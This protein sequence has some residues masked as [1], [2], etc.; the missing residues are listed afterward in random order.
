MAWRLRLMT[1]LLAMALCALSTS[2]TQADQMLLSD[3]PSYYWHFGCSPTSAMM[4]LGYW[5]TWGYDDLIPGSADWDDN[6]T[7]IREAIAS[8]G[9]GN[10]TTSNPGTPG[11]GHVADYAYYGGVSDASWDDPNPDMSELDP[12]NAHADDCLADF[13]GTS[14]SVG[15]L[16]YGATWTNDIGTGMENYATWRSEAFESELS[17]GGLLTWETF[18]NE[19]RL[20]R[21]VHFSVDSSGSGTVD[22]SI[23]AI[24]FRDINGYQEYACWDTWST[25]TV[26][27]QRFRAADDAYTWGV[28]GMDTLRPEGT[29]DCIWRG[30]SGSWHTWMKWNG[31]TP[32]SNDFVSIG[33]DGDVSMTSSG[34]A[35]W[36]TNCGQLDLSASLDVLVVRNELGAVLTLSDTG[37]SLNVAQTLR[38]AAAVELVAGALNVGE[39]LQVVAGDDQSGEV[40][41]G[42]GSAAIGRAL[43]LEGSDDGQWGG[44]YEIS[45]GQLVVGEEIEVAYGARLDWLGGTIE[46]A[47]VVVD[48]TL[49]IGFSA[50]LADVESGAVLQGGGAITPY[51]GSTP[52]TIAVV[53]GA[54]ITH[55]AGEVTLPRVQVGDENSA[56]TLVVSGTANLVYFG[57]YGLELEVAQGQVTQTGGDVGTV[58][59]TIAIRAAGGSALYDLQAGEVSTQTLEVDG[60]GSTFRQS[61]GEVAAEALQ[62]LGGTYD[63][64]DGLLDVDTAV[65]WPGAAGG[66]A[67]VQTGGTF[68]V[69]DW[70]Y[71]LGEFDLQGGDLL[72]RGTGD[73]KLY[74]GPAS[75]GSLR[76]SGGL[77]SAGEIRVRITD[78]LATGEGSLYD[79]S[80]GQLLAD[81]VVVGDHLG[82]SVVQSGGSAD[83]ALVEIGQ[84]SGSVGSWTISDGTLAA[85]ELHIGGAGQGSLEIAGA[86]A[87]VEVRGLLRLGAGG[88]LS[89]VQGATIRMTGAA[90]DNQLTDGTTAS[91]WGDLEM[92]FEGGEVLFDPFEI[93]CEDLGA[94]AEGFDADFALG[95]LTLGGQD[96]GRL[97][98]LD[99]FDNRPDWVGDE[100]LYVRE[101]TLGSGSSLDLNGFTLYYMLFDDLGGT[102]DLAGGNLVQVSLPGDANRDGAVSDADYTIWADNYLATS[103]TWEMGD[104]NGDKVVS[105]ADYTI[106]ADHYAGA[107]TGFGV[108]EP[109]TL[110][111]LAIAGI[112]LRRRGA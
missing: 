15:G 20:G 38:N 11:T 41:Q 84:E 60:A 40:V 100:C 85:G 47:D 50:G 79:L 35:H 107:P 54:T 8:K 42:G 69:D 66:P 31:G 24:G 83:V 81:V 4:V 70:A 72:L 93:A 26:R 3:V 52:G 77:V 12:E 1:S 7:A 64:R 19:I 21:P 43:R 48:G 36:I 102:I 78:P 104:F 59:G 82:S 16:H 76:Q 97:E 51:G 108:P 109:T 67:V 91:G 14:R 90:F 87:S 55:D 39:D 75:A 13:M 63:L 73:G 45:S 28:S 101:L 29:D 6:R 68:Q 25:T 37:A 98:L 30:G 111:F 10:G 9:D 18:T 62:M 65:L 88:A 95:A 58:P 74:I 22:H 105:D 94:V 49:G 106:W 46:C 96:V 99:L 71:V 103:A 89:A 5:D 32:T 92:V 86:S 2:P 112:A 61:G 57:S 80:G 33:P 27:W 110:L 53:N 17:W 23:T 34:V 44:R 56:G